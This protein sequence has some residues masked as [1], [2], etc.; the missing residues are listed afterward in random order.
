MRI[1][2]RRVC[3]KDGKEVPYKQVAMGYET[4][5]GEYVVLTKDEIAA[6]AGEQSHVIELEEF[7]ER[8]GDRPR[9]L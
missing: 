5:K 9:P 7:V 6:A 4:G 1:K 2:Q 8:A 3:T